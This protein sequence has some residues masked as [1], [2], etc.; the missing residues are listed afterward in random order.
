MRPIGLHQTKGFSTA[1][2]VLRKKPA[3]LEEIFSKYSLDKMSIYWIYEK[4]KL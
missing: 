3:E 1:E 4:L 2:K